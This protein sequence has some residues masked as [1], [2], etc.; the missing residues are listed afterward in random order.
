[1]SFIR[2]NSSPLASSVALVK[3]KY[4]LIQ[5]FIDY[6]ILNKK[7]MKN[8]Y[9]ITRVDDL[10]DELHGE[11][12]F[13]KINLRSEYHHIRMEEDIHK[14]TFRCH[15][16]HFEFLVMPFRLTNT[17]ATF[18]LTMNKVFREQL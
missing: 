1:M 4:E 13:S 6:R 17:L 12:Y 18:Q 15:Y 11:K 9:P 3:K 16:D 7:K 8:Q 10:I 14:T 2:S 5:M